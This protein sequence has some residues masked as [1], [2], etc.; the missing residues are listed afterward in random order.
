MD[1]RAGSTVGLLVVV[2]AGCADAGGIQ[3]TANIDFATTS[4][5]ADLA[6]VP[7]SGPPPALTDL[8]AAHDPV[9][10][11]QT[12][13]LTATFSGRYFGTSPL[14]VTLKSS[15]PS[16]VMLP[17]SASLGFNASQLGI[18]A[19]A[20]APGTATVTVGAGGVD[21]SVTVHVVPGITGITPGTVRLEVGTNAQITITLSDPALS[22]GHDIAL[23]SGDPSK[24]IVPPTAH[25]V[26]GATTVVT[27]VTAVDQGGPVT[28][29]ATLADTQQIAAV[30]AITPVAALAISEV[31]YDALGTDTG[32]E[33]VELWN[34]GAGDV[35]LSGYFLGTTA[36]STSTDYTP[37][38][39]ALSGMLPAGG[40]VVVGGPMAM[41]GANGLP[42][43]FVFAP[44]VEFNPSLPNGMAATSV[45]VAL[46]QGAP[47]PN[48]AVDLTATPLVDA[49]IYGTAQ[50]G[51]VDD[52]TGDTTRLDV[53]FVPFPNQTIERIGPSAWRVQQTPSGGDCSWLHL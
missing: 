51:I 33:W 49:V 14:P 43:G 4:P 37:I 39:A 1:H 5:N 16:I 13:A 26:E 17:A 8:S 12:L 42:A 40:C 53:A 46:F 32:Y 7:D 25:V 3:P 10:A 35:D 28:I 29:T 20:L 23:S 44:A 11:G 41:P 21:K 22:G 48:K 15:D 38:T 24:V 36:T 18:S 19:A 31:L 52:A 9:A 6:S 34:G 45:G 50:R 27:G 47:V 30:Y 2:L